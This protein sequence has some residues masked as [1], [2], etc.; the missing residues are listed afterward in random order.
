MYVP[1]CLLFLVLLLN[2]TLIAAQAPDLSAD[3]LLRINQVT[4]DYNRCLQQDA[5][6]GLDRYDDIRQAA[7]H[8]VNTCAYWLDSL[9][10]NQGSNINPDFH[11]GLSQHIRTRAI[12]TLLPLLMF[13]KSSREKDAV[14]NPAPPGQLL[15][16]VR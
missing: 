11:A 13:E 16:E 9:E 5:V 14:E 12:Q 15:P 10:G 2:S 4:L 6:Q 8:A 7:A 3:D 1:T